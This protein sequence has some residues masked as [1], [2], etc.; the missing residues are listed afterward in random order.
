MGE[1]HGF[2]N[3][4]VRSGLDEQNLVEAES[5]KIARAR[6]QR[7]RA[8]FPIQKS[9]R[10]KIAQD[11]IE[12]LER[13]SAIRRGRSELRA[14]VSATILSAN[15][16]PFRQRSEAGESEC[17]AGLHSHSANGIGSFLGCFGQRA[18]D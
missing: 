10:A 14:K 3:G 6:I 1:G 12:K 8:E 11:T 7:C 9:S 2:V 13:E 16:V 15:S 17:A 4:G 18:P 5:Q